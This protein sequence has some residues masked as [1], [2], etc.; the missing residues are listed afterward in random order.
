MNTKIKNKKIPKLRFPGFGGEWE[1]RML[2][3]VATFQK[4]KG[5]SKSD[6][7][8]DGKFDCIRYGE[9]YTKYKEIIK[10]IKSKTNID[11][12]NL[13]LSRC[14]DVIIPASGETQLDIA[15]ASCVLKDN[16][17]LG[18]DINIIRGETNGVFLSYYLN[19]AKKID[20]ARLSQ[21]ISVVHLYSSQLKNL[22]LNIPQI[23]EQQKI[24]SFL[25]VVDEKIEQLKNKKKALEK[26]KKGIMQKIFP[27]LGETIPEIRF[28]GFGGEWEEKRLGEVYF[29]VRTNSFSRDM[30]TYENGD[31]KN[32]HYGDIHTKFPTVFKVQN[33]KVPFIKPYIDLGKINKEDFCVEG[34]LVIADASE[35]YKDIGKTIEII[36]LNND[37]VVGG[38]HT[39]IARDRDRQMSKG[40]AGFLLQ[41]NFVRLQFMKIATG[42]S[43]LGISKNN[44]SKIILT[45]PQ[46][47]EQQ[48]IASFLSAIGNKIDNI[49]KKLIQAEDFKKGL[50]Q[51]LF[52]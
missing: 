50:L 27:K 31:V 37:K 16:V 21:G 45:I 13:V 42:V 6:I 10:N 26:Y 52:V 29:F 3:D 24:A 48:K 9:L 19:N 25:S 28:G 5:V 14:N 18:G 32:I 15:T 23:Q 34:D 17:I 38:L 43:V 7:S 12:K 1:E 46:K 11:N 30:L 47:K 39:L 44:T 20:I 41:T 40:F 2:G 8:K 49:N 33:E 22:K 51:G 35:D 4:G 36:D